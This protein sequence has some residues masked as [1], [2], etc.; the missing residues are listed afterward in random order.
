MTKQAD[1]YNLHSI[2]KI[3]YNMNSD[4]ISLLFLPD[5]D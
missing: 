4:P 2:K 5:L 3:N 1:D